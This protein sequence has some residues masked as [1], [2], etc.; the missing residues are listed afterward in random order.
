M[1]EFMVDFLLGVIVFLQIVDIVVTKKIVDKGGKELNKLLSWLMKEL[2][3]LPALLVTK[4]MLITVLLI[5]YGYYNIPFLKEVL[6]LICLGYIY[7]IYFNV[8][9]LRK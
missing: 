3:V 4:G 1:R 9:S 7:V 2:G 8:K 6:F 5:A